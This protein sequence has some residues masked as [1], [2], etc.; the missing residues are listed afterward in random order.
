MLDKDKIKW[1][2][3]DGGKTEKNSYKK[4]KNNN[5][6]KKTKRKYININE[7]EQEV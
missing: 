7:Q 4:K 2:H 3:D 1:E 6:W 5:K